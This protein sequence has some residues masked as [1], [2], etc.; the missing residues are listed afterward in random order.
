MTRKNYLRASPPEQRDERGE[1]EACRFSGPCLGARHQVAVGDT[2]RDGVL[3]NGGGLRVTAE[4]RRAHELL[5]EH[6]H[7]ERFDRI[8]NVIS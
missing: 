5:S 1:Q 7:L 4:R 6:I 3:L 2:D 8:G